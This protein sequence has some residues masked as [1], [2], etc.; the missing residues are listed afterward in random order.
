M[1]PVVQ[2][3]LVIVGVWLA[4]KVL[5]LGSVAVA[6]WPRLQEGGWAAYLRLWRQWD[7]TWFESIV[8]TGYGQ[9]YGPDFPY[10]VNNIAF[11]PGFP[12]LMEAGTALGLAPVAAGIAV[13]AIASLVAAFAIARLTEGVGGRGEWG[14]IALL[15]APT[16]LF[17]TAAY[18]EALFAAFAFWAWVQARNGRW[19]WAG[20]LAGAA[21]VVRS[22]G[23]FLMAGLVLMFLLSRP[24]RSPRPALE[25][26]KGSALLLPL[27]TTMAYFAYL[28][29]LT[30]SW[31]AWFTAQT[32]EWERGFVNPVTALLNTWERVFTFDPASAFSSRYVAELVAMALLLALLVVLSARR[33]WP[34]A[35]YTAV[36]A[37]ALTTST[38]YHSI[39]RTLVVIFPLWMLIGLLLTRRVWMRWVYVL[40]CLP[41]LVLVTLRFTQAQWIS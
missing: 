19:V 41:L 35:L 15:V 30:S 28:W 27:V 3:R 21:A 39:P 9:P 32:D 31:T 26:A 14:V 23:L 22:N 13:S 33:M 4:T 17:L 36:T 40:A 8:V 6:N 5:V 7:T 16:A 2:R 25:W 18:T 38:T 29:T 37:A 20:V 11:F 34:E 1:S 10:Y 24:W 12:L